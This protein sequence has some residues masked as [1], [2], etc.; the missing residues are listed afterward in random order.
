VT[1]AVADQGDR[2]GADEVGQV[3]RAMT[4]TAVTV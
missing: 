2:D 4:S 3:G 1:V